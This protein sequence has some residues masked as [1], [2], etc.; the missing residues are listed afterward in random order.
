MFLLYLISTSADLYK[1]KRY[2]KQDELVLYEKMEINNETYKFYR[3]QNY[4]PKKQLMSIQPAFI[5]QKLVTM[6]P[7]I[8][9]DTY[10]MTIVPSKHVYLEQNGVLS[11]GYFRHT[12]FKNNMV[13]QTFTG[14][15]V[16]DLNKNKTWST[17]VIYAPGPGQP[18]V[19]KI[20]EKSL[21]NYEILVLGSDFG[22]EVFIHDIFY[23]TNGPNET[24]D[25]L[26]DEEKGKNVSEAIKEDL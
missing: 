24:L 14:G 2:A 18:H 7:I 22:E 15:S 6:D 26:N 9:E 4:T 5:L 1:I 8:Y 20:I 21:C 10:K 23:E 25:F 19:E 13:V 11:L 12:K 3:Y 17:T 16:C